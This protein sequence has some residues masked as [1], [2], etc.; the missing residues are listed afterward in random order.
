MGCLLLAVG[1]SLGRASIPGPLLYQENLV[2]WEDEFAEYLDEYKRHQNIRALL[3]SI[4]NLFQRYKI[5][6][7]E[8]ARPKALEPADLE[9]VC[10]MF[11]SREDGNSRNRKPNIIR[12]NRDCRCTRSSIWSAIQQKKE[13]INRNGLASCKAPYL[14]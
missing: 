8:K 1:K 9:V 14:Y 12:C 5:G 7:R 13:G 3:T 2:A 4:E 11:L 10:Y 6:L